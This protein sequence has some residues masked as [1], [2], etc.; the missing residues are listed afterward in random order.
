MN[1]EF[2]DFVPA[3]LIA[4]ALYRQGMQ[5]PGSNHQVTLGLHAPYAGLRLRKR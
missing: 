5:T 1:N 4:M 2:L 3:L